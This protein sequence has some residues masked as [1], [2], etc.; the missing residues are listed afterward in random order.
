MQQT[1]CSIKPRG[2]FK[3]NIYTFDQYCAAVGESDDAT[4]HRIKPDCFKSWKECEDQL[5]C[6]AQSHSFAHI[7]S[8]LYSNYQIFAPK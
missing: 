4:V 6:K 1:E 7:P 5:Y 2:Q 8:H 3:E